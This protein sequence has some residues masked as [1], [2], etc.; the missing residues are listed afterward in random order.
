[1][2]NKLFDYMAA[3]LA[4]VTSDAVP[5]KRIVEAC[6]CGLVYQDRDVADL[7]RALRRLRDATLRREAATRGRVAVQTTYH[8]ERDVERLLDVVGSVVA[9]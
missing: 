5:L 8:W 9:G 1:V 6:G 4:V 3:G 2:P 7:A